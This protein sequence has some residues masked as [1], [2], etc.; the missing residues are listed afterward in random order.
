ML[1]VKFDF[2]WPEVLL[3]KKI[4]EY[5]PIRNKELPMAAMF[6]VQSR[7]ETQWGNFAKDLP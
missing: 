4:F 1:P 5:Q 7:I 3:E 6:I 2:I